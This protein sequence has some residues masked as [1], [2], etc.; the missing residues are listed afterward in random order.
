MLQATLAREGVL[1]RTGL[2]SLPPVVRVMMGLLDG[3]L[4]QLASMELMLL[5]KPII[6]GRYS[7][8]KASPVFVV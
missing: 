6:S 8:M 1:W 3:M 5:Q 7:G 4:E 2:M